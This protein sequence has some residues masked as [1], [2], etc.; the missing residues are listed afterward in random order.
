MARDPHVKGTWTGRLRSVTLQDH[1]GTRYT[2][3]AL[4]IESGPRTLRPSNMTGGEYTL[5]AG[6]APHLTHNLAALDPGSLGIPLG[7]R[8]RV[9]GEMETGPPLVFAYEPLYGRINRTA[10]RIPGELPGGGLV[11]DI[12]E[13]PKLLTE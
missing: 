9:S 13:D 12:S 5:T 10:Y 11:L 3:A 7:A 4:E 2:A 8:V 6:D 1:K